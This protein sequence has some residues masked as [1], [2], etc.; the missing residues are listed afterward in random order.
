MEFSLI[1]FS[2]FYNLDVEYDHLDYSR[3]TASFKPHYH[4]MTQDSMC[5][6][7]STVL[8]DSLQSPTTS[9]SINKFEE[10]ENNSITP[11]P[12]QL[13]ITVPPLPQKMKMHSPAS[14]TSSTASSTG[15]QDDNI[16]KFDVDKPVDKILDNKELEIKSSED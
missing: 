1:K 15:T 5:S 10:K 9:S 8:M 11:P 16:D 2:T 13:N 4:R 7:A 6:N 3:P 12:K 14:S